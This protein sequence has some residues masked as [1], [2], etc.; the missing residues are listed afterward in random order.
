[1]SN[2]PSSEQQGEENS[3]N[4]K[5]PRPAVKRPGRVALGS[6]SAT[7]SVRPFRTRS[8]KDD[9]SS[10]GQ[11]AGRRQ[12][13]TS[14]TTKHRSRRSAARKPGRR[15]VHNRANLPTYRKA[16]A[17]QDVSNHPS[18][19]QRGVESNR[20]TKGPRPAAKRPGRVALGCQ[21]AT[22]S[23]RPFRTRFTK[24]RISGRATEPSRRH[25]LRLAN[26]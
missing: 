14:R 8:P 18:S 17:T 12:T 26:Y 16:G 11:R 15:G 5:G 2:R 20:N 13:T 21:S 22:P 3:R 10:A 4:T 9:D 6:Q 1:M 25:A 24:R 7:P 19:E 23:V